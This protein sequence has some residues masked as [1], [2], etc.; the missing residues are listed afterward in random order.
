M[1][2]KTLA[3]AGTYGIRSIPTLMLF[4]D[5]KMASTKVGAAPKGELK[6]MDHGGDLTA[7]HFGKSLR[8]GPRA[9]SFG[10]KN[11]QKF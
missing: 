6:K 4:K 5:G 1:S 8:K 10:L 9:S 7:G 2:M 3:V 11:T